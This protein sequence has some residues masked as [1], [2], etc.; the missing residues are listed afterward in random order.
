M[1]TCSCRRSHHSVTQNISCGGWGDRRTKRTCERYHPGKGWYMEDYL[2]RRTNVEH[3]SWGIYIKK[4]TGEFPDAN[5]TDS[6]LKV[7]IM[8][9]S[10]AE[11]IYP[12]TTTTTTLKGSFKKNKNQGTW[13]VFL[14]KHARIVL[15]IKASRKNHTYDLSLWKHWGRRVTYVRWMLKCMAVLPASSYTKVSFWPVLSCKSYSRTNRQQSVSDFVCN[16][17][18]FIM[19]TS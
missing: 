1:V 18:N 4:I 5:S 9:G 2:L 19:M 10:K 6:E 12:N 14:P 15:F 11:I 17:F 13:N 8:G 16:T 7:V 3:V